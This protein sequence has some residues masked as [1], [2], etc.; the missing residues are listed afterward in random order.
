MNCGCPSLSYGSFAGPG[1][2]GAILRGGS[3]ETMLSVR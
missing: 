1:K 2:R 3:E